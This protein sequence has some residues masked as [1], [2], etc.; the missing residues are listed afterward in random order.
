MM[1]TS[2]VMSGVRESGVRSVS[3]SG[4]QVVAGSWRLSPDSGGF[5][6][7]GRLT[8]FD[9]VH[10]GRVQRRLAPGDLQRQLRVIDDAA[11]AAE[12]C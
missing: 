8:R 3:E 11:V 9:S 4:R 7:T 10:G 1:R 12:A 5:V 6:H 2:A